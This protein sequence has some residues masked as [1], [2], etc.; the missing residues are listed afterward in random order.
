MLPALPQ[1]LKELFCHDNQLTALPTLPQNIKKI[2]CS[3]NQLAVL[4]TLPQNLEILICSHN[5][6]Y[7]IVNI[8]SSSKIKENIQLL[9]HYRER[10]IL[11]TESN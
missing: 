5:P 1:N 7:E 8:Q 9:N 2:L 11:S 10:K 6:V 3:H 4:P